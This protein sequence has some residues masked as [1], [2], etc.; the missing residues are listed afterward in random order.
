MATAAKKHSG[1]AACGSEEADLP[2]RFGCECGK[3]ESGCRF[4]LNVSMKRLTRAIE[5]EKDPRAKLRLLAC[6]LRRR[7]HSI[8][9]ICKELGVPY[10]AVRD[11]LVRMRERGLK[12]RFNRRPQGRRTWDK[13][14]TCRE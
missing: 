3:L 2:I 12:G 6:R 1:D 10:S 8:R 7:N 5:S 9:E 13:R 11:W 4:M 14:S